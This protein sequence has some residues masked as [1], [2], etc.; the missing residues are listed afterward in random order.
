MNTVSSF[1][2]TRHTIHLCPTADLTSKLHIFL[3]NAD[4][5]HSEN[6]DGLKNEVVT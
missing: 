5:Y 1:L 2:S 6:E 4:L 3:V